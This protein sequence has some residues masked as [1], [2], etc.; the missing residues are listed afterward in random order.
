MSYA[1][2]HLGLHCLPE[3]L[4]TGILNENCYLIYMNI[5]AIYTYFD[6]VDIYYAPAM[7]MA[8]AL[9]VTPVST[10]FTY[11]CPNDVRSPGLYSKHVPIVP[12]LVKSWSGQVNSGS[13]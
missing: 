9:C 4:F 5:C 12:L 10:Y 8:G 3:Y 7:T 13:W 6:T 1:S 11:V 2:F